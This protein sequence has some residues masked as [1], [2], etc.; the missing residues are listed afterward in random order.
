M[1]L[2]GGEIIEVSCGGG[3]GSM[4]LSQPKPGVLLYSH[5]GGELWGSAVHPS[6]HDLYVT[7]GDDCTL[8]VWS[9]STDRMVYSIGL[10]W[11]AR[12]V[13]FHPCG[14]VVA[15]G[16][17]E[18][19]KGGAKKEKKEKE[20]EKDAKNSHV[21]AVHLYSFTVNS[22]NGSISMEKISDGCT[23]T[24]WV[25][26]INFSPSG[27]ILAVG[28]H[29]KKVYFYEIPSLPNGE[30]FVVSEWENCLKKT[31]FVFDKHSSAVLHSDFSL[32]GKY[33]QTDSQVRSLCHFC[34]FILVA[35]VFEIF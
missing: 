4:D 17:M 6:V 20:K 13:C 8:R 10:G 15:V 19:V 33:L 7:V 30:N 35:L 3:K 29:D 22:S 18:S 25:N 16:F 1:F 34:S 32:D 9:V 31:K 11:A 24:A 5:S 23:T 21:G 26:E 27:K 12:C 14:G 28:S 2:L